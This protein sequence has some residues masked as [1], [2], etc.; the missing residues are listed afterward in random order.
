MILGIFDGVSGARPRGGDRPRSCSRDILADRMHSGT[1][2]HEGRPNQLSSSPVRPRAN[3]GIHTS[4][5]DCT[6]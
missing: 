5:P 6:A 2:D 1:L 4:V 3:I